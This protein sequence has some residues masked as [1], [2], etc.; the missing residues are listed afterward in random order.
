MKYTHIVFD[1]DGTILDTE[2]SILCSL[3]QTLKEVENMH[4]DKD[5]L[6]FVLGIPGKDSLK[7]IDVKNIPKVIERWLEN[8]DDYLHTVTVFEGILPLI[9]T[10]KE[11]GYTLGIVTSKTRAEY[12]NDFDYFDLD[13]HFGV[14]I[15]A[16]DTKLHKPTA[17]PLLKYM[18][19]AGATPN[20]TIYIGDSVYD[21]GCAANAGVDFALAKWGAVSDE[22]IAK[23]YLDKPK[24]LLEILSE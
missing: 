2:E 1:I 13:K 18:E 6:T 17:E 9:E 14:T 20:E 11:S 4:F 16:D 3:Q 22:I 7:T 5:E 23:Y 19:L 12:V 15:C 24:D 8:A 21:M 10:L